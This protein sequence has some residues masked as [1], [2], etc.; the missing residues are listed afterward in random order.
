M[1]KLLI[2]ISA[3]GTVFAVVNAG[4]AAGHGGH[5]G[6]FA[7]SRS[8]AGAGGGRV[9]TPTAPR[10]PGVG[11]EHFVGRPYGV[12]PRAGINRYPFNRDTCAPHVSRTGKQPNQREGAWSYNKQTRSS[13]GGEAT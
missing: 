3:A 5:G 1:N 4:L 8:T 13:G 7:G 10:F 11:A 6:G 12:F 2:G 9:Y